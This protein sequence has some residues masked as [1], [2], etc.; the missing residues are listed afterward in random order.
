MN[1]RCRPGED[2]FFD[3]D[4][5]PFGCEFSEADPGD[6]RVRVGNGR[7]DARFHGYFVA[8]RCFGGYLRLMRGLV[9]KHGGTG[10][11]A[12]RE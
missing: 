4:G 10:Y 1:G 8:A 6:L 9:G 2:C 11:V 3:R 12:D 5:E 7:D